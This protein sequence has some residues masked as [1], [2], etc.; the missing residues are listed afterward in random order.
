M[1]KNILP[2]NL[3]YI[4][5]KI[6]P[7]FSFLYIFHQCQ[8]ITRHN[9]ACFHEVAFDISTFDVRISKMGGVFIIFRTLPMTYLGINQFE[10]NWGSTKGST[11]GSTRGLHKGGSTFC[12]NPSELSFKIRESFEY[13][14]QGI[15]FALVIISVTRTYR[16]NVFYKKPVY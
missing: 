12:R 15:L 5:R 9:A 4:R 1:L 2:V 7:R 16:F 8:S 10:K 11:M 13:P 6:F 3:S 14:N